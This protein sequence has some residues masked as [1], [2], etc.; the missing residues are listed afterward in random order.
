[1]ESWRPASRAREEIGIESG[2]ID[3]S[4]VAPRATKFTPFAIILFG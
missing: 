1:M 4:R 3:G 2:A